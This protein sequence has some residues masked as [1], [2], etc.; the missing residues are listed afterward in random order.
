MIFRGRQHGR[1]GEVVERAAPLD[2]KGQR[3]AGIQEAIARDHVP[4]AAHRTQRRGE[5]SRIPLF[6]QSGKLGSRRT[7]LGKENDVVPVARDKNRGELLTSREIG[8]GHLKALILRQE[9]RAG[10]YPA[11]RQDADYDRRL[12]SIYRLHLSRDRYA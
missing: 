1:H 12:D 6:R 4:N 2:R 8:Y 11:H 5:R 10:E 9:R 3:A 7:S